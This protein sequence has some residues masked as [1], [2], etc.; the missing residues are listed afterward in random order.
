LGPSAQALSG[1]TFLSGLP[2]KP[3]AGWGW[4]YLDDTGGMYFSTLGRRPS[5]TAP[6]WRISRRAP[7]ISE[8]NAEVLCGELG[9][10]REELI[11]LAEARVV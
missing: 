9:L 1:L 5:T 6:P 7:L 10:T 8:H 2:G 4:S 11:L 3:P